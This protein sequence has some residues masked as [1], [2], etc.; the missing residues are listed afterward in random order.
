ME[1]EQLVREYLPEGDIMQLATIGDNKPWICTV[2]YVSDEA[3][4]VY[5]LSFPTRRHSQEIAQ[6]NAV[7]ITVPLKLDKPVIGIQ[8]EGLAEVVR[9][10]DTVK[11]VM[12]QYIEKYNSG[13]DFYSN[14]V[15][16]KNQHY[17]YKCMPTNFVLFDEVDFTDKPRREWRQN[18]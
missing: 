5:W 8:A 7:A 9:D 18:H 2:Y 12:K 4:N 10:A 17:M 15:A 11:K 13:K 3:L 14:F 6:N 16:G 1:I